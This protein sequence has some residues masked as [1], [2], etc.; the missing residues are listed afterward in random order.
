[1]TRIIIFAL[2]TLIFIYLS[3]RALLNPRSHGFYRFFVFEIIL[4][5]LLLNQHHWFSEP[6]SSIHIISWLFLGFSIYLVIQALIVL[7]QCG[8]HGE[9][10]DM[11]ENFSFENTV[12]IVETGSYRYIRHPMYGSLLF[13][14][15]GTFL[16]HVTILNCG[17]VITAT[18]LLIAVSKV[19]E[20]ENIA[21]FGQPY[22]DYMR[23]TN[24]FI[25]QFFSALLHKTCKEK[26]ENKGNVQLNGFITKTRHLL[27]A[28]LL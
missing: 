7:R 26:Q 3:H 20:N 22:I 11:P 17:M 15:W 19:E 12:N 6:F 8:G 21:Y 25:P 24:M 1:M 28:C 2:S 10:E 13:L 27:T 4:I 9:R 23:R 16:K 18:I 14:A 5:L